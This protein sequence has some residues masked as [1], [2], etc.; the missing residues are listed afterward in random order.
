M[1][2]EKGG[3]RAWTRAASV[4]FFVESQARRLDSIHGA[5]QQYITF[6]ETLQPPALFGM[7]K[8]AW[9]EDDGAR[10]P[11]WQLTGPPQP[12]WHCGC[13]LCHTRGWEG[14]TGSHPQCHSMGSSPEI[15]P[16][17]WKAL[18]E[19]ATSPRYRRGRRRHGRQTCDCRPVSPRCPPTEPDF[20]P[21]TPS[22]CTLNP[23]IRPP[24]PHSWW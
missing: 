19:R 22:H 7:C 1:G 18:T 15:C 21:P 23:L 14:P 11:S 5:P 9:L 13:R 24:V 12:R 10:R 4:C 2:H 16:S 20:Q 6:V 17:Q 3:G 8:H